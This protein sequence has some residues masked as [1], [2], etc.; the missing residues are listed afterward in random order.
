MLM[1]TFDIINVTSPDMLRGMCAEQIAQNPKGPSNWICEL[2]PKKD[3]SVRK[4]HTFHIRIAA[5]VGH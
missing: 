4:S 1:D 2:P 5:L 3:A